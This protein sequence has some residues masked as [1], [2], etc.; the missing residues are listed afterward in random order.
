MKVL[1]VGGGLIGWAC[2]WELAGRGSQVIVV[3]DAR[4]QAA[5]PVAAGLL[6][7]AGGRISRSHLE[8]K[9][10][11]ARLYPEF[12]EQ[13]QSETGL[14]CR[15]HRC[16]TLT[17]A[18][19][20]GATLAVEGMVGCLN[21]LGLSARALDRAECREL[22]PSLG[23][24]VG[25]G[26]FRDDHVV[27]PKTLWEALRAASLK[28]GVEEKRATVVSV[29]SNGVKLSGGGRLT[30]DRVL[31][32]SGAWLSELLAVEL[33]PLKGETLELEAPDLQL[34][35]NLSVQRE[36]LYLAYR[37]PGKFVL[38]ATE[39]ECGFDP[40]P[41]GREI[42][43]DRALRLIPSLASATFGPARVGFRPKVGDG[44]PVLGPLDGIFVAGAHYRNGVLLAPVTAKLTA[45]MILDDI[46]P[47]LAQ[48]LIP[49][50]DTS[51][52]SWR[53]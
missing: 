48:G 35:C 36:S 17:V 2:A 15:Y 33:Y 46:A 7:P 1:V 51:V 20:P 29:R 37:E 9:L 3:D 38:G 42:L 49:G 6:I 11:S 27:D 40:V 18:F 26:Y 50:R 28:K 31:V 8:L 21:G 24:E 12:I 13:L 52:K 30:G 16:G 41:R 39:E 22:V 23:P 43:R 19:E 45:Q 53:G 14:D 44:L 10:E 4:P 32:A 47:P 5:S 25:G 34:A